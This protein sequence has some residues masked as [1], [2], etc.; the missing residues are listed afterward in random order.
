MTSLL[1]VSHFR[2][3]LSRL[4]KQRGATG[5]GAAHTDAPNPAGHIKICDQTQ[6]GQM[7]LATKVRMSNGFPWRVEK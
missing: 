2:Y 3:C 4:G 5:Q 1:T 6:G 7:Y